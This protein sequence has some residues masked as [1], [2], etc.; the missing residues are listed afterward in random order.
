[1]AQFIVGY[2]I[3]ELVVPDSIRKQDEKTGM[4]RPW[5][6]HSFIGSASAP[7]SKFLSCLSSCP[8]FLWWWTVINQINIFPS[9]KKKRKKKKDPAEFQT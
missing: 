8:N 6:I 5:K 9:K 3:I 4:R 1:M 2:A 7:A